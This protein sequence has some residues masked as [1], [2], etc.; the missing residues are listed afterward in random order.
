MEILTRFKAAWGRQSAYRRTLLVMTVA[1]AVLLGNLQLDSLTDE[2]QNPASTWKIP[3]G[4]TI[5]S[6]VA[7]G[8]GSVRLWVQVQGLALCFI[9]ESVDAQG[10]H[11][12]AVS[13]SCWNATDTDWRSA[14]G[15][16][17]FVFALPRKEGAAMVVTSPDGKRIG[18]IP[19]RD[20]LVMMPDYW[21]HEPV[22]LEL[23]ALDTSGKELGPAEARNVAPA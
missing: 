5:Q 11:R 23:Q 7:V 21:P 2:D 15:M 16:G 4:Y 1:V 18:P 13:G 22:R 19:A 3:D 17:T 12:S 6:S 14:R 8:N 20:G 9:Q 10:R